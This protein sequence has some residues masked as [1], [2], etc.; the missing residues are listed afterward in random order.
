M[1]QIVGSSSTKHRL[2][3]KAIKFF[4][5]QEAG[6]VEI[7]DSKIV[8]TAEDII[9]DIILHE[10][11]L[12]VEGIEPNY[13]QVVNHQSILFVPVEMLAH[14][15]SISE[16]HFNGWDIFFDDWERWFVVLKGGDFVPELC[17]FVHDLSESKGFLLILD[18]LE[19]LNNWLDEISWF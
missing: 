18:L 13:L 14:E 6:F 3:F 11:E 19:V 10:L 16:V 2:F 1:E 7:H 5:G 4:I 8:E 12:R 15:E 9:M 17:D